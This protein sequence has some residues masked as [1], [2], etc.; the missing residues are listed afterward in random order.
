MRLPPLAGVRVLD[1]SEL[2]PGPF[3][4]Q[5]LAELGAT[6]VKVERPPHGD[7]ARRLA[8]GLFRAVNRGKTCRSLDLKAAGALE[9]AADLVRASD[10]LVEGFR[11]GVMERLGLGYEAARALNPALVYVSLSGYGQR[12]PHASEPGHDINYLARSGLLA[13]SGG[14][15]ASAHATGVPLADLCGSLYALSATLAALMQVRAGGAGQHLDVALT[16][17]AAHWLNPRLGH[18]RAEGLQSL[19][20][21]RRDVFV[22]PAYGIFATADGGR[23][24]I[25]A[26]EDGFWEALR[27]AFA[28]PFMSGLC[29]SERVAQ[30][31]HINE[32]L[33]AHVRAMP[34]RTVLG[35]LKAADLPVTEL[36]APDDV[37][38]SP[39]GLARGLAARDEPNLVRFPVRIAGMET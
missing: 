35:L 7:N 6:V 23:V 11:P 8:P 25:A 36:V 15:E 27:V 4:T 14:A 12:G 24:A 39:Q 16:D 19:P 30:A 18:F 21:Q 9:A 3:F 32:L 37:L 5:S 10:V 17:C 34:L 31:D 26:L 1:F 33:S 28:L 13:L 38:S 22:K 20:A 29:Y 2:L